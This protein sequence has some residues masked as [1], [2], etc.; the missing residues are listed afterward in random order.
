M[1][2]RAWMLKLQKTAEVKNTLLRFISGMRG[3]GRPPCYCPAFLGFRATD[4]LTLWIRIGSTLTNWQYTLPHTAPAP[5]DC[6]RFQKAHGVRAGP[7]G[8]SA[9]PRVRRKGVMVMGTK[10]IR[11]SVCDL[12]T[13]F[14][15]GTA[16]V[17]N[18]TDSG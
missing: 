2:C 14:F 15:M 1:S 12:L 11:Y 16:R 17:R 9:Y 5:Y 10:V 18:P 3:R 13:A 8:T 7:T 4:L 6:G